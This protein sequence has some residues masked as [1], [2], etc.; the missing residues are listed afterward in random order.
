MPLSPRQ[1]VLINVHFDPV[2]S[3]RYPLGSGLCTYRK[4]STRVFESTRPRHYNGVKLNKLSIG[5][6]LS[7]QNKCISSV[8]YR[9]TYK[10]LSNV[11][12]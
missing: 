2:C 12:I 11:D 10:N 9:F 6:H 1:L 8:T 7:T 3:C 5:S 4:V